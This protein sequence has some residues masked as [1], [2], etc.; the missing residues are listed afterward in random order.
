M[1]KIKT[2]ILSPVFFGFLRAFVAAGCG[3]L[4]THGVEVGSYT[5]PVTGALV[6]ILVLW[7]SQRSKQPRKI[8]ISQTNKADKPRKRGK[9]E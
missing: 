5:E 4:A 9:D 6:M 3:W 2:I 7:W 8:T 1:D